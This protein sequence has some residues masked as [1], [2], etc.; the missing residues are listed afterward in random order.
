LGYNKSN[1]E[2]ITILE[3]RETMGELQGRV[4]LITGGGRGLGASIALA[5][6]SAGA[7]VALLA[8]ESC[9]MTTVADMIRSRGG[10]ALGITADITDWPSVHDA[11]E[12]IREELGPIHILVN[13]AATVVPFAHIDDSH[14]QE[15]ARAI[16][17][18]LVGAFYC[19]HAV[20]TDMI[21]MNWGR[22]INIS[23]PAAE[24]ALPAFSAYGAAK[25]G[26]NQFTRILAAELHGKEVAALTCYPGTADSPA[27]SVMENE[28][29][30]AEEAAALVCWLCGPDGMELTG[31]I[32][33]GNDLAIR[34][35]IG[36]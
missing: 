19:A 35:K 11:I 18:N 7:D 34:R 20:I 5:L 1:K 31:Q 12:E 13:Q 33:D 30:A 22:I 16:K 6:A 14:P 9:E 26:L 23:S 21:D 15:W 4:A 8:H 2:L 3:K 27:Q 36:L 10:R 17:I 32:V 25:A 28:P 29:L 24:L